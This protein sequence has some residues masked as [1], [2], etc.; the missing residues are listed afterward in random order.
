M[1][2]MIEKDKALR[3]RKIKESIASVALLQ[4]AENETHEDIITSLVKHGADINAAYMGESVLHACARKPIREGKMKKR[5]WLARNRALDYL[6]EKGA[7]ME[8]TNA[9]GHT[10]L[11][12][13]CAELNENAALKIARHKA[14]ILPVSRW[15]NTRK[16]KARQKDSEFTKDWVAGKIMERYAFKHPIFVKNIREKFMSQFDT[17]DDGT[18]S[19]DEVVTFFAAMVKVQFAAGK[20]PISSFKDDGSLTVAQIRKLLEERCKY[21]LQAW[22]LFDKDKDGEYTWKELFPLVKDFWQ[23]IWEKNRPRDEKE[24]ETSV[25]A[26]HAMEVE[27]GGG[28]DETLKKKEGDEKEKKKEEVEEE[29]SSKEEEEEEESAATEVDQN[30]L[31]IVEDEESARLPP[32]WVKV[33]DPTSKDC[34]YANTVTQESTWEFPS[35]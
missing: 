2:E 18:L 7:D 11:V 9:D 8:E 27:Y 31:E 28:V 20:D 12:V 29:E 14:S 13:A 26:M 22:F 30:E 33:R 19:R 1:K 6:L 5:V 24:I 35:S 17:D 34:Y 16:A 32:N 10:P 4:N 23:H 3:K 21:E 15:L 25:E